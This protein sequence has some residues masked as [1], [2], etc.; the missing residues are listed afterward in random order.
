MVDLLL[1]SRRHLAEHLFVYPWKDRLLMKRFV[2]E[3]DETSEGAPKRFITTLEPTGGAAGGGVETETPTWDLEDCLRGEDGMTLDGLRSAA[4]NL[5]AV[6]TI[7]STRNELCHEIAARQSGQNVHVA[8]L[9][10]L[11][12]DSNDT[13]ALD[14]QNYIKRAK[15]THESALWL[16]LKENRFDVM[17]YLVE[18]GADVNML[19]N[20][21]LWRT[22]T[23]ILLQTLQKKDAPD[24]L[25]RKIVEREDVEVITNNGFTQTPYDLQ[26]LSVAMRTDRLGSVIESTKP[27]EQ[28][29]VDFILSSIQIQDPDTVM[30]QLSPYFTNYWLLLSRFLLSDYYKSISATPQAVAKLEW[31]I[32]KIR[33][34]GPYSTYLPVRDRHGNTNLM[35][36]IANT[37]R[38]DED[39]MSFLITLSEDLNATNSRNENALSLALQ[40]PNSSA[41]E[42]LV[43]AGAVSRP[44]ATI[45]DVPTSFDVGYPRLWIDFE[46]KE[47]LGSGVNGV[48]YNVMHRKTGRHFALKLLSNQSTNPE[49]QADRE[50]KGLEKLSQNPNCSSR[51]ACV[52]G[53]FYIIEGD[54]TKRYAILMELVYGQPLI[55]AV[56]RNVT[57]DTLVT[58]I[59]SLLLALDEIHNKGVAHRDLHPDNI[60][61]TQQP[62][63]RLAWK[64]VSQTLKAPI[65]LIDFGS[66]CLRNVAPANATLPYSCASK[67]GNYD[68][69]SPA[70]FN[71]NQ[72]LTFEAWVQN[73]LYAAGLSVLQSIAYDDISELREKAQQAGFVQNLDI[74]SAYVREFLYRTL[75]PDAPPMSSARQLLQHLEAF[76]ST[77]AAFDTANQVE[78]KGTPRAVQHEAVLLQ[79]EYLSSMRPAK[80]AKQ[81]TDG[82]HNF[83]EDS[84]GYRN[85]LQNKHFREDYV[86]GNPKSFKEPV[87]TKSIE[88]LEAFALLNPATDYATTLYRGIVNEEVKVGT[89]KSRR[90]TDWLQHSVW[91]DAAARFEVGQV[92][93]FGTLL[94]TSHEPYRAIN[95]MKNTSLSSMRC[96]DCC[97]LRFEVPRSYPRIDVT[98]W[99]NSPHEREVVLPAHVLTDRGLRLKAEH[100]LDYDQLL[101]RFDALTTLAKFAVKSIKNTDAVY[102]AYKETIDEDDDFQNRLAALGLYNNEVPPL[103]R[104]K[105]KLITLVPVNGV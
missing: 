96:F 14:A 32:H 36:Y 4:T 28:E 21:P 78:L 75:A 37:D 27:D 16:A 54:G 105:V 17:K 95:F 41:A 58:W 73:D 6:P 26:R 68:Y 46:R 15:D 7:A 19:Y 76:A 88:R 39:I 97:L 12:F 23:T 66:A 18:N 22:K 82:I 93:S 35:L 50:L 51:V 5:G 90:R 77:C 83:T 45:E 98:P 99:S 24:D 1:G 38:T 89:R 11:G 55:E 3:G 62:I 29:L 81:I 40:K 67:H 34:M 94:S 87:N 72:P 104:F 69:W 63:D 80:N 61:V 59:R 13:V 86:M 103:R 60:V 31:I 74:D 91:L 8:K 2:D 92:L 53:H 79:H 49:L 48:V 101:N 33:E 52:Y 42:A 70:M 20:D 30:A 9:A 85:Y 25:I 44:S 84:S 47:H 100:R 56:D 102:R 65:V 57:M 64:D 43:T 71:E 10:T